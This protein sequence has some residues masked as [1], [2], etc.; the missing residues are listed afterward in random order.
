MRGAAF[1]SK[2]TTGIF[3]KTL[4][5]TKFSLTAEFYVSLGYPTGVARLIRP[6]LFGC[7]KQSGSGIPRRFRDTLWVLQSERVI[8]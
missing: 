3:W 6:D 1:F 8:L 7:I 5:Q 2:Y 4:S